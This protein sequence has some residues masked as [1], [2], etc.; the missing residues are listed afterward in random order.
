MTVD[1]YINFDGNCREAL[2]LYSRVFKAEIMNL[3]AYS[4]M[5]KSPNDTY[6]PA[7]ADKDRIMHATIRIGANAL[8]F[9]DYPTGTTLVKGNNICPTIGTDDKNEVIR[10]YKAFLAE[11]GEAQMELGATFFSEMFCIVKDKFGIIWQISHYVPE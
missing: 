3:M 9:S 8:M 6:A 1:M 10:L 11:G 4:D 2:E 5:P 7:E